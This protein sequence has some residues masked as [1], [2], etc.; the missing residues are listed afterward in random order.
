MTPITYTA[1][2]VARIVKVAIF[3]NPSFRIPGL[4]QHQLRLTACGRMKPRA[5]VLRRLDLP[6]SSG[7]YTWQ[8]K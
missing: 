4:S 6:D 7:G 8:P 2:Q 1:V 3:L 5:A